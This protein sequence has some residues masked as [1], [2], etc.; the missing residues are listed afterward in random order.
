MQ[1]ANG[2]Y[3]FAI[4]DIRAMVIA[5]GSNPMTDDLFNQFVPDASPAVLDAFHSVPEAERQ[6]ALNILYLETG[7]KR[8]LVDTG[9]GAA[10]QPAMGHLLDRLRAAGITPDQIEALV[11]SHFHQDHVSGVLDAQGQSIFPNAQVYVPRAEAAYWLETPDLPAE[12]VEMTRAFLTPLEGR[13]H[14]VGDGDEIV[15]GVRVVEMHGHTAGHV[16]LLIESNGERLLHVVDALHMPLQFRYPNVGPA[17][18]HDSAGSAET[19][20]KVLAR[21]ADEGLRFMAYHLPFPGVGRVARD[22]DVF[23]WTPVG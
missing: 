14:R 8:L 12:Y 13:L 15:L 22:G 11:I 1:A 20:R 9:M 3:R 18:D 17:F 2:I 7:G 23:A 10:S 4:G 21:A 5:D 6:L 19:R 16:G